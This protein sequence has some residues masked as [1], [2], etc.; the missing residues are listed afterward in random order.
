MND[1]LYNLLYHIKLSKIIIL[2]SPL[3]TANHTHASA[4]SNQRK[5]KEHNQTITTSDIIENSF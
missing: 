4:P 5:F 3:K 2:F 1:L